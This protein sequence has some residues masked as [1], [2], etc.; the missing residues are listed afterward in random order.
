MQRESQ[1]CNVFRLG[2]QGREKQTAPIFESRRIA[3]AARRPPSS[4][5]A[6][7]QLTPDGV[8]AIANGALPAAIQPVLQVLE[9]R[10]VGTTKCGNASANPIPSELERYRLIL[11]DGVHAHQAILGTTFNPFVRDG[12]L[13]EGTSTIVQLNEFICHTIRGK[14]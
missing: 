14:R 10:R 2:K 12:L 7:A 6:A 5:D 1:I 8:Q 4:L 3:S 11:S 9:L 13:R